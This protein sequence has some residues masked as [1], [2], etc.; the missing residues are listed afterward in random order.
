MAAWRA[1]VE[2][3]GES[4]VA[5]ARELEA[6]V[7]SLDPASADLAAEL[8]H[9]EATNGSTEALSP[10]VARREL[11]IILLRLRVERVEE[12]IREARTLLESAQ[13][14]EPGVR[15]TEWERR[16][17]ELGQSE[18]ALKAQIAEAR[19]FAL[20]AETRRS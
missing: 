8:L 16:I 19:G 6:F 12:E 11:E 7:A 10:E 14:E 5:T 4:N 17:A 3:A 18:E 1:R 13:R 2:A 15:H 9:R 20:T